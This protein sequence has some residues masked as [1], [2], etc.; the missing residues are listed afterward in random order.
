M[1]QPY[2]LFDVYGVELEY[3]IVNKDSLDV[4]PCCDQLFK[5]VTGE[6]VSDFEDGSISWSNELVNHVIELKT[7]GPAPTLSGLG[8]KFAASAGKNQRSLKANRR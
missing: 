3:M 1:R 4:Q 5:A 8:S 6:F 7:T 2:G